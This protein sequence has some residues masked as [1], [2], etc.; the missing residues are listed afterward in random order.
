MPPTTRFPWVRVLLAMGVL[1]IAAAAILQYTA[2]VNFRREATLKGNLF[3]M[4]EAIDEYHA[5]RGTCPES[6]SQL[7]S[8]QYM[9]ALPVDPLTKSPTWQYTRTGTGQTAVCDVKTTSSAV[10]R[11]GRRYADW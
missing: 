4:R 5:D 8:S 9:R 3:V 2:S 6:L 11:D 1:A 10:A 7:V